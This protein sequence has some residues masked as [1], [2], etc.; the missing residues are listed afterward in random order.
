MTGEVKAKISETQ[1][2]RIEQAE[3]REARTEEK[4]KQPG[5]TQNVKMDT[6]K[7]KDLK[8]LNSNNKNKSNRRSIKRR[9]NQN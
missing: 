7:L 1:C 5:E 6:Y 9:H 3:W 8:Q 4:L 2:S